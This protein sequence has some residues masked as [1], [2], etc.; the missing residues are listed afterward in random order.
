MIDAAA[1]F[2]VKDTHR[3]QNILERRAKQVAGLRRKR[4]F[5]LR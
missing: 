2:I 1:G 3:R 4:F 5:M